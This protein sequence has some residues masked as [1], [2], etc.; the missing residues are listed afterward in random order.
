MLTHVM[1]AIGDL[2]SQSPC[3]NALMPLPM[4]PD[5]RLRTSQGAESLAQS[6]V[7]SGATLPPAMQLPLACDI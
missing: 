5:E 6:S 4:S 1:Y 7:T 2:P 3:P